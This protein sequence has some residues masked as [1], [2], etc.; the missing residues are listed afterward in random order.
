MI[1]FHLA[2]R[3]F[4]PFSSF[5]I[6]ILRNLWSELTPLEERQFALYWDSTDRPEYGFS[7]IFNIVLSLCHHFAIVLKKWL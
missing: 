7:A 3:T 6:I 5:D 4:S 1:A 2:N